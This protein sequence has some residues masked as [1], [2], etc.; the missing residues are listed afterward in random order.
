MYGKPSDAQNFLYSEKL[1]TP[2]HAKI[3]IDIS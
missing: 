1:P 3:P 2:S